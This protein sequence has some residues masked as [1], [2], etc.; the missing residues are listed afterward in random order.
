MVLTSAL[1]GFIGMT[2][3]KVITT[4]YIRYDNNKEYA[5]MQLNVP[6]LEHAK[7][8]CEQLARSYVSTPEYL[9]LLHALESLQT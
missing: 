3:V 2:A 4:I 9:I 6:L 1:L 8:D 5:K 7:L